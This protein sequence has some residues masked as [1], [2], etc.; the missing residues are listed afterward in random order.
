MSSLRE[1][2]QRITHSK[3]N[4]WVKYKYFKVVYLI[5]VLFP[6]D[7]L[8]FPRINVLSNFF[9]LIHIQILLSFTIKIPA[10][11][12][13][14]FHPCSVCPHQHN[15]KGAPKLILIISSSSHIIPKLLYFLLLYKAESFLWTPTQI[16][17][18]DS[19]SYCLCCQFSLAFSSHDT[20]LKH[21]SC[22]GISKAESDLQKCCYQEK[23]AGRNKRESWWNSQFTLDCP[24]AAC[25]RTRNVEDAEMLSYCKFI[26]TRI[27]LC[28]K[29]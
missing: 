3:C 15:Q 6:K 18:Q 20:L 13:L 29:L 17:S 7:C 9:F 27:K 14:V 19:M 4:V 23:M 1:G 10:Q 24:G 28:I 16:L 22:T 25:K 11:G 8:H 2:W 5:G 26:F 21:C 12:K